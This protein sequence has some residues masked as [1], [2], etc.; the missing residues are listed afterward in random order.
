MV[1]YYN[2]IPTF[3]IFNYKLFIIYGEMAERSIASDCKSDASR[4]RRFKSYSPQIYYPSWMRMW[5]VYIL[6][7]NN[8]KYYVWS[9]TDLERR[10]AHHQNGKV[11]STKYFTPLWLLYSRKCTTIREA[12]QVEYWLK[13]QKDRKQIERFMQWY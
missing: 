10:I 1:K 11:Q 6:S 12:R 5:F 2:K 3:F 4:L 7:M 8:W 13:K 9:T